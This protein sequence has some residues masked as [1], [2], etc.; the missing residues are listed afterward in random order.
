MSTQQ[1]GAA[2]V[3]EYEIL[4]GGRIR[5]RGGVLPARIHHTTG[6]T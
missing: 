5:T 6:A 1:T 4:V 3:R 2:T